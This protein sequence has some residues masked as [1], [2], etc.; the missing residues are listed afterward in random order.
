MQNSFLHTIS[1]ACYR[2]VSGVRTDTW[3]IVFGVIFAVVLLALLPN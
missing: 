1:W 3:I 2:V